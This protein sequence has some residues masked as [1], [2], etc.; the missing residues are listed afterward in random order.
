M[1]T[2]RIA[3]GL[4]IQQGQ[5][6]VPTGTVGQPYG[7]VQ[8]TASGGGTQTWSATQ[9]PSGL[10]LSSSGVLSGTPT[11]KSGDS[12]LTVRVQDSS[13]RSHAVTYNLPVRD[14]LRLQGPAAPP[15]AEVGRRLSFALQVSGGTEQWTWEVSPAEL[16]TGLTLAGNGATRV[17]AGTPEVA[18]TFAL[19][20]TVRDTEGRTASVDVPLVIAPRLTIAGP[21]L[22]TVKAGRRLTIQFRTRGGVAGEDGLEWRLLRFR[23]FAKISWDKETGRLSFVP[24]AKRRSYTIMVRAT[25]SL[26]ARFTQTLTIRVRR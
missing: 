19:K 17:L 18:G 4:S 23:P 1:I 15:Q 13:G 11:A 21:T 20:F 25:D 2:I 5:G 14:A 7:P 12:K 3:P 16:P 24:S 6:A 9:I 8:F 22:R 26:K 10:T